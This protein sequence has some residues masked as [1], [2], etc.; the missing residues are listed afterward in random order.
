MSR[1]QHGE[2]IQ[3]DVGWR[4]AEYEP[5]YVRGHVTAEEFCAAVDHEHGVGEVTPD[6]YE[7]LKH[8]WA[9]IV[10]C[11]EDRTGQ[12]IESAKG[13]GAFA[14]T[15]ARPKGGG[16]FGI[17]NKIRC[18]GGSKIG[19]IESVAHRPMYNVRIN[20]GKTAVWRGSWCGLVDDIGETP[21]T[22]RLS[23]A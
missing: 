2:Y 1:W 9:R 10:P 16:W 20:D 3:L 22:W 18:Y 6:A 21:Q 4:D 5:L 8:G 11:G 23:D 17:G 13:R 12:F 7:P 15:I 14:V 19:V